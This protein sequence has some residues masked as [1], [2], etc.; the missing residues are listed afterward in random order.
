MDTQRLMVKAGINLSIPHKLGNLNTENMTEEEIK[1][2]EERRINEEVDRTLEENEIYL[3][4]DEKDLRKGYTANS[5][6][7]EFV[8]Y[9]AKIFVQGTYNSAL[10]RTGNG[11]NTFVPDLFRQCYLTPN[12]QVP[13]ICP[14]IFSFTGEIFI[15]FQKIIDKDLIKGFLYFGFS[16]DY[17]TNYNIT[18]KYP[19]KEPFYGNL[20]R[21]FDNFQRNSPYET[22]GSFTDFVSV[23]IGKYPPYTLLNQLI[24]FYTQMNYYHSNSLLGKTT[25]GYRIPWEGSI[26]CTDRPLT[27]TYF[28]FKVQLA[29]MNNIYNLYNEWAANRQ[30]Q[31]YQGDITSRASTFFTILTLV[32]EVFEDVYVEFS[33]DQTKKYYCKKPYMS[34]QNYQKCVDLY[35]IYTDN[36]IRFSV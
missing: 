19:I 13:D 15:Y 18:Q 33:Y 9:Q 32:L 31:T 24:D 12:I 36:K 8:Q 20:K 17:R 11:L 16:S 21:Y 7:L 22:S 1:E 10:L 27:T 6:S 26:L 25:C 35:G 29:L 4:N 3:M 34:Q 30:Y 23:F 2:E 14:L 28:D 5:C